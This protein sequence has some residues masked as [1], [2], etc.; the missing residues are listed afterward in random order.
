MVSRETSR[1]KVIYPASR[2]ISAALIAM[3]V[4]DCF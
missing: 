4:S 1:Q 2:L 3:A